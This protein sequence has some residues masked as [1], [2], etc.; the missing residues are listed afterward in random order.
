[1]SF[2]VHDSVVDV[3]NK[4]FGNPVSGQNKSFIVS[5]NA[6]KGALLG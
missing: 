4:D 1:M 2:I 6:E 3:I 5:P